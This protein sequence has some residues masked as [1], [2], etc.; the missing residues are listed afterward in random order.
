VSHSAYVYDRYVRGSTADYDDWAELTG[1]KS[2]GAKDM[3]HY[4]RKHQTLEPVDENILDRT[5]YPFVGENHGT[6]GPCRTSFNPV[7]MPIEDDVIKA[8]DEA[9]GFSVKP[10]DPWSGDHIGFY[11]T[12]GSVIRTGPNKGKRSYVARGYFEPN[13]HR[14]NLTVICE[15]LVHKVL[16]DGNRAIGVEFSYGGKTHQVKANREVIVSGGA[17]KTPQILELSGIGDPDILKAAGIEVKIENKGVGANVQ[18]HAASGTAY[19]LSPGVLSASALAIP[20]VLNAAQEELMVSQSGALTCISPVQGFFPYKLFA[21]PEQ[22]KETVDSI[23]NAP[24][25]S[26]FH[27]KQL[28]QVIKHLEDDKSANLQCVLLGGVGDFKKGVTNQADLFELSLGPNGECGI[29]I[30]ICLQYPVS[31]GS[32]HVTSDGK[33][34]EVSTEAH[35]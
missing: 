32:I 20:E 33:V 27:R 18:D 13:A 15:S 16:L 34:K 31:R 22:L 21:T 28:D 17:V 9:C 14:P 7:S 10:K 12:L 23:K 26:E 35:Y 2:W 1:D 30:A 6:S 3:S 19:Y 25:T 11:N 5:Q 29:S 8:A 24:V 4:M